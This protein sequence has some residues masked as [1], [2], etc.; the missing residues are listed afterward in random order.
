MK[1]VLVTCPPM[2][3]M[4]EHFRPMMEEKNWKLTTPN[5]VQIMSEDELLSIVP[6]HDGWIIGDD[7]ANAKVFEAGVSGK[8]KAA[9]KWGVGV[10]NVDFAAAKRLNLP[11]SN[12]PMMFGNEVAD[13]G[14]GYVL[15]LSRQLHRIDQAVRKNEWLKPRGHSTIGKKAGVI[16]FGDIG[17][18]V[19]KRLN[20]FG[21]DVH[22]YD[23]FYKADPNFSYVKNYAWPENVGQC[24]FL[25]FTCALNLQNRHML[26]RDVLDKC[27]KG[28]SIINIARGPLICEADLIEALKSGH[29][30]SAG[31]DVFEIEP[32]PSASPLR[33]FE[34]VI[35]GSH[36]G[37]NTQEAVERATLRAIDLLDGFFKERG[38]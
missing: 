29:V 33:S 36:N 14:L 19:V 28:V 18:N 5:V 26:N 2:L 9:V 6:E 12:T 30:G 27:K 34:N 38:L 35:L 23:P 1:K 32:L 13:V 7:P 10:D 8:L 16:G 31:L 21:M 3:R 11:I 25:I 17:K 4:I 37:S 22:V 24:D 20:A 15:M